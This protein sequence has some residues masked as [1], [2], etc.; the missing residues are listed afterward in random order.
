MELDNEEIERAVQI[1]SQA[2][3]ENPCIPL[4]RQYLN[5]IL[6]RN[7]LTTDTDGTARRTIS[8][9]YEFVL[10]KSGIDKD[11]GSIWKD[12]I[13]FLKTGPGTAGGPN[14][15]DQQKMDSLRKVYRQAVCVPTQATQ[16][17]WTDYHRFET[18]LNRLTAN[19][20]M[21]DKTAGFLTAKEA[22][23]QLSNITRNLIRDTVPRLPPA[24]GFEGDIEYQE[25]VDIWNEWIKWELSDPLVLKEEDLA[26]FH[27][28]ILYVYKQATM[29]MPFEPT[30][31]YE[32]A[33]FCFN[34]RLEDEATKFLTQGISANPES[35]LLAFKQAD[36]IESTTTHQDDEDALKSRG[37]AVRES[38]NKVLDAL[39]ALQKSTLD[40]QEKSIERVDE[41]FA[42]R[43]PQS[44]IEKDDNDDVREEARKR[45]ETEREQQVKAI[46]A[47]CQ[48]QIDIIR[49]TLSFAWIAM[50]RA[51]RR[52]QGKGA[53]D[54]N[55]AIGGSRQVFA[56]ARKRGSL[57]SDVYVASALMEHFCYK[58]PSAAR[59]F[60]RGMTLFPTD[61]NFAMEYLKHL[62]NINDSQS[63]FQLHTDI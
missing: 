19:K 43:M 61:E 50:M 48:A 26:E 36:R 51:M 37:A 2:L 60:S 52:V 24:I 5:F 40:R 30:F 38:Y 39:Y 16:E 33:E 13:D 56:Q 58:D 20:F 54:Q 25:Q 29:A 47:G 41:S 1:F 7:N 35:C 18:G 12:Y 44:A 62:I 11:S 23:V 8:Q 55:A 14:W 10:D 4:W 3:L 57:T 21:Q 6:R 45:L 42:Q 31:W 28:R 32:A 59:I 9:A 22:Y 27:K 46:K 15:L 63:K 49:R 53:A 17:L 34:N